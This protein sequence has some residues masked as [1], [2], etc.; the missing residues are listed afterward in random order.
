MMCNRPSEA[1]RILG[2]FVME[3]HNRLGKA[4]VAL[5]AFLFLAA[6]AP[7]RGP[8][9]QA[10]VRPVLEIRDNVATV[11]QQGKVLFRLPLTPPEKIK[12][13]TATGHEYDAE[14]R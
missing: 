4:V 7:Q 1:A 10:G 12:A 6:M 5:G 11:T 8:N 3:R 2:V 13:R 9:P 14:R